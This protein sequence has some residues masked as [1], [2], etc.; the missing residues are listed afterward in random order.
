ML[1]CWNNWH[2]STLSPSGI[3]PLTQTN[4]LL[5]NTL[6]GCIVSQSHFPTSLL[7]LSGITFQSN[8]LSSKSCLKIC[9]RGTHA[10]T[11]IPQHLISNPSESEPLNFS[12][13]A[14]L[15]MRCKR[16]RESHMTWITQRNSTW[17]LLG[18]Q[19][20][21]DTSYCYDLVCENTALCSFSR[22]ICTW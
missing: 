16:K 15:E 12:R 10:K 1:L 21:L 22:R 8:C 3:E 14:P 7:V 20:S 13:S 2:V 18:D 5:D 19:W 4:N 9:F 17:I 6:G 11:G